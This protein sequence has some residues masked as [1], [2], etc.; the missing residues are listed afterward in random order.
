M[1][2]MVYRWC[3]T[4]CDLLIIAFFFETNGD[5]TILQNELQIQLF[6]SIRIDDAFKCV[7]SSTT[8]SRVWFGKKTKRSYVFQNTSSLRVGLGVYRVHALKTK[9]I[10]KYLDNHEV[11][12]KYKGG[13]NTSKFIYLFLYWLWR[14]EPLCQVWFEPY[15]LRT[16]WWRIMFQFGLRFDFNTILFIQETL[17]DKKLG[18]YYLKTL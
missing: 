16:T 7:S 12:D 5:Q 1:Q 8:S 17:S 15:F 14:Y 11:T 3:I 9:Q 13:Y 6:N 4:I 18:F 10:L 2:S